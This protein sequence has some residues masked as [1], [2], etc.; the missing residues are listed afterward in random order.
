MPVREAIG[1]GPIHRIRQ[2]NALCFRTSFSDA[3][4]L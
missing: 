2:T 3:L 4:E 1:E